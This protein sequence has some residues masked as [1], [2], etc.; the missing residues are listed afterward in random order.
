VEL[1]PFFRSNDNGVLQAMV[2][3]GSGVALLPRLAIDE[4]DEQV[5]VIDLDGRV[6]SR[7][8]ALAW[9]RERGLAPAARHFI[10]VAVTADLPPALVR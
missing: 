4:S 6:P 7:V 2:G 9:S 1:D 8:I 10:D 5:T 3:A